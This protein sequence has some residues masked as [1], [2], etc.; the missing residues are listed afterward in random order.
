MRLYDIERRVLAIAGIGL[1]LAVALL[2]ASWTYAVV[3]E[4]D[5][6]GLPVALDVLAIALAAVGMA[7]SWPVLHLAFAGA[8][9]GGTR[10][11]HPGRWVAVFV[12][13]SGIWS[14]LLV[15]PLIV[16]MVVLLWVAVALLALFVIHRVALRLIRLR[17]G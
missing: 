7:A 10:P 14:A 11:R 1:T 12:S 6:E 5:A 4:D 16:L 15:G 2:L 13:A 9:A 17:R 8:M 3:A